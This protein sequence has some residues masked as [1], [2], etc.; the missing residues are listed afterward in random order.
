MADWLAWFPFEVDRFMGSRKVQRMSAELV[1]GYLLLL[2][3]QWRNGPIPTEDAA[4][5]ARLPDAVAMRLLSDCFTET[6]E[7]WVNE[8][9]EEIREKAEAKARRLSKAGKAGAKALWA[10]R[11]DGNRSATAMRPLCDDDGTRLD[12]TTRTE[13]TAPASPPSDVE[14]Y[15]HAEGE[16][17][18]AP[19]CEPTRML[20]ITGVAGFADERL[21]LNLLPPADQQTNLRLV[22]TWNGGG[23]NLEEIEGAI[24]GLALMVEEGRP[25]VHDWL[26][27]GKPITLKALTANTLYDQGDGRAKRPLWDVAFEF[28][29][30]HGLNKPAPKQSAPRGTGLGRVNVPIE[31]AA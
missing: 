4:R 1:G 6:N 31:P 18:S 14:K 25:E 11:K 8:A 2:I 5:T 7:G 27:R 30:G 16:L 20:T 19:K 24:E 17:L 28:Y 29:R 9:Q 10:Q 12:K 21:G 3:D 13:T 15:R 22:R 26:P 23:R